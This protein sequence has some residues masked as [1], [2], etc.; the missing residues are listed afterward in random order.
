VA[1]DAEADHRLAGGGDAVDHFFGPTVFNADHH[2]GRDVGVAAR[3]YQRAKVQLQ[4]GAELQAAVGVRNRHAA[5]DVVG[6]GLR[7]SVG[8]VVQR[9][10][11]DVVAHADAAVLAAIAQECGVFVNH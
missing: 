3:A 5:L 7:R 1:F 4:V 6:H 11:D 9:Q 2:H 10:D 8:Q